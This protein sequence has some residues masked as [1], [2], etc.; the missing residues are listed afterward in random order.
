MLVPKAATVEAPTYPPV[1]LQTILDLPH[2]AMVPLI[3]ATTGGHLWAERYDRPEESLFA[4]QDEVAQKVAAALGG[5]YGRL[6]EARRGEAK[7]R[8]PASLD[9]YD[10]YLLGTEQ[11]H[12]FTR[13]SMAE[14]IR[15]LS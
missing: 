15:L 12:K 5:W 2:F 8:P 14:A 4:I 11:K 6:N 3:D 9:A 10:L 13:D 7:R 1:V